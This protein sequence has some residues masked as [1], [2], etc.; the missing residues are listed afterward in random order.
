VNLSKAEKIIIKKYPN[1]RLYNTQTSI[2][3]KIEDLIQM[4]KKDE[5]FQVIDVKNNVD[6]TRITLAQILLELETQG[7]ALLPEHL[8][9]TAIKLYDNP[10]HKFMHDYIMKFLEDMDQLS[11]NPFYDS[12]MQLTKA[13]EQMHLQNMHY[14]NN[15]FKASKKDDTE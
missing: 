6:I 9:K 5:E 10:M 3:I 15:A 14:F 4:V 2:Y 1:R 8:I 13:F 12:A 11:K 7:V